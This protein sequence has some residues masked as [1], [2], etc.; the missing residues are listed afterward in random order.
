MKPVDTSGCDVHVLV[1][2]N[3]RD[4]SSMPSCCRDGQ[5]AGEEVYEALRAWIE[6]EGLLTRVWLTRTACLGWCHRDGAT[7]VFYPEG[8]WYRGVTAEDCPAL[9]EKHIAAAVGSGGAVDGG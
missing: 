2:V 7:L 3:R 8:A 1:C 9:I 6:A 5:E 4:G